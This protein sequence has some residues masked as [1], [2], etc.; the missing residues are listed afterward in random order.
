LPYVAPIYSDETERFALVLAFG[1]L[2]VLEACSAVHGIVKLEQPSERVCVVQLAPRTGRQLT[3]LA[4]IHKFS[5]FVVHFRGD[6]AAIEELVERIS[7]KTDVSKFALSGYD[8]PEGDYEA[9]VQMLLATFRERGLKKIRLLRPKGNEL[10][11]EEVFSRGALDII[12]FPYQGGYGLAPTVW[13]S[14]VAMIKTKALAKPAPTPEISMS[15]RL[16]QTLVNLS[17]LSPGQAL[18]DPFC[19]SGTIL[20]EGLSRSLVC[21][22]VDSDPR[23]IRDAKRNLEWTA[24]GRGGR[25]VLK[26]GDARDLLA[27]LGRTRVDGVVTEPVLLPRLSSRPSAT[28]AG[29]LMEAA[30]DTY[31]RALS[32][33]AD[34]LRPGG[35]VVMV[36]P[37][38]QTIDGGE[39]SIDLD[40]RQLGFVQF[41]PGPTSFRYPVRL[42]FES[43]RWVKR[44]VYV[45]E[46]RA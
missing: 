16:A 9:L 26:V 37:V 39:V 35:R 23:R 25:Y 42:S 46:S 14:D 29:E 44:S 34:V 22:G 30:G 5:P 43:T 15:P 38:L 21:I 4:G 31:A 6:E 1:K 40:A 33:I 28:V 19:G 18:L 8:V 3:K 45:F 36:V 20:A 10:M 27:L 17:T 2:S 13:V 11:A 32:S 41:Q 24:R 7:A 12:V